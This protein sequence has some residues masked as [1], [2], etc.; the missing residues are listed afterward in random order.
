MEGGTTNRKKGK[1]PERLS[2]SEVRGGKRRRVSSPID[3]WHMIADFIPTQDTQTLS[4]LSRVSKTLYQNL[5]GRLYRDLIVAA[6]SNRNFMGCIEVLERYVSTSQ[7]DSLRTN[8]P[9]PGP[10]N[11]S[12]LMIPASATPKNADPDL[13]PYCARYVKRLLVGWSNPGPGRTHILTAYLEQALENLTE[14][15]V[16][17]WLDSH[18]SFTDTVG[19]R[20]AKLNLK[21]FAFNFCCPRGSTSLSGIKNLVYLDIFRTQDGSG[22]RELLWNSKDTLKTL[23]YEEGIIPNPARADSL[24]NLLHDDE[25]IKCL[26]SNIDFTRLTYFEFSSTKHA[27]E[28]EDERE[29]E[30]FSHQALFKALFEAYGSTLQSG[31]LML[32]TLR[33]RSQF[34]VYPERYFLGLLSSFETL[35]TFIFEENGENQGDTERENPDGLLSALSN[36]K[37]LEWLSIHI[38]SSKE[39]RWQLSQ[40]HFI[41]VRDCFPGLKHLACSYAKPNEPVPLA[42]KYS[43]PLAAI[44]DEDRILREEPTSS[45]LPTMPNLVSYAMPGNRGA[46]SS[47]ELQMGLIIED[48]LLEFLRQLK[49]QSEIG[50]EPKPRRWEDRYKLSVV[51]LG[52]VSFEVGSEPSK[53]QKKQHQDHEFKMESGALHTLYIRRISPQRLYDGDYPTIDSMKAVEWRVRNYN[54]TRGDWLQGIRL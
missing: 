37:N 48:I 7:R 23:I 3:V 35:Q 10:G 17:V 11:P 21:A 25:A 41:K 15:E 1:A 51:T 4:A 34:P 20:L 49:I 44:Y 46:N 12:T 39:P 5:T 18:I 29:T 31:R 14:L 13:V 16:L 42:A 45:V 40:D 8:I 32:K 54:G 50:P 22:I 36:H 52:D 33:F 47:P 19:Q 6:P 27:V 2:I 53:E 24:K 26:L 38:P 30:V 43:N 9:N 28:K